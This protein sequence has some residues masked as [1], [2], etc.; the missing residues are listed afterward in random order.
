MKMNFQKALTKGAITV[1]GVVGGQYGAKMLVSK[2]AYLQ[3]NPMVANVGLIALG[4]L[5]PEL[6]PGKGTKEIVEA[7]GIGFIAYGGGKLA[8]EYLPAVAGAYDY[9]YYDQ[10]GL[11]G[12]EN[13]NAVAGDVNT[14]AVA[15]Y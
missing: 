6:V 2:V 10:P 14:N 4:A 9:Q 5:L 15:D 3:E 1:A 7:V 12:G 13:G 8:E 11:G